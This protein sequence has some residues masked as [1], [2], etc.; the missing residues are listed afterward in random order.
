MSN[1]NSNINSVTKYSPEE[2]IIEGNKPSKMETLSANESQNAGKSQ[3]KPSTSN[4]SNRIKPKSI[5]HYIL[6]IFYRKNNITIVL[7]DR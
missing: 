5:G 3:S 7:Y 4:N 6:G 1:N 2:V